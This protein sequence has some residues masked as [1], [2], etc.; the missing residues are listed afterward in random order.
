MDI[1]AETAIFPEP[2]D[3]TIITSCSV[4]TVAGYVV[5]NNFYR[6]TTWIIKAQNRRRCCSV[7]W[8]VAPD[9]SFSREIWTLG[10]Q[11]HS[12][13]CHLGLSVHPSGQACQINIPPQLC[14]LW[15]S[16][17]CGRSNQRRSR[18]RPSSQSAQIYGFIIFC[19]IRNA[20]GISPFSPMSFPAALQTLFLPHFCD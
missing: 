20:S 18:L 15:D 12:S 10:A 1:K 7:K 6:I 9:A 2:T 17:L 8:N 3:D 13:A 19:I 4:L 14:P 11:T 5:K 16:S